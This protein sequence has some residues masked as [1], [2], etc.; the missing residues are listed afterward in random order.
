M[1]SGSECMTWIIYGGGSWASGVTLGSYQVWG[2]RG[3]DEC[4]AAG[5]NLSTLLWI[6]SP[7]SAP[8]GWDVLLFSCGVVGAS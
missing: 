2:G 7:P 1:E 5:I 3:Q 6:R 4:E 8:F